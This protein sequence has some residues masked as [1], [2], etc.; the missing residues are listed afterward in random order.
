M[1]YNEDILTLTP[2][3]IAESRLQFSVPL[4]QRLFAWGHEQVERLLLD[5]HEH[6]MAKKRTTPY[7]LGMITVAR[8]NMH[9]DLIDGQQRFTMLAL[10]AIALQWKDFL[11]N[12]SFL[13]FVGRPD[14]KAY[15]KEL[16]RG[17]QATDTGY[18]NKP[19]EQA[20][21]QIRTF[22]EA[23][24][25]FPDGWQVFAEKVMKQ[26]TLFVTVLDKHYVEH[27]S[28]LNRYFENMNSCGKSLE[29]H[30]ILKV[31]LLNRCTAGQEQKAAIWNAV[32]A[33]NR[34][35]LPRMHDESTDDY[36]QRLKQIIVDVLAEGEL[37]HVIGETVIDPQD[38]TT[39]DVIPPRKKAPD[40][41]RETNSEDAIVTFPEFLLMVLNLHNPTQR[42]N[43]DPSRLL[44]AFEMEHRLD[45]LDRFY[46][47][48]LIYRLL[49]DYYVVR[50]EYASSGSRYT[51]WFRDPHSDSEASTPGEEAVLQYESMLEVSTSFYYWL[52][53]LL[54]WLRTQEHKNLDSNLL[55]TKLKE[56]DQ[57]IPG[58]EEVPPME[59][60]SYRSD[61]RYWFWLLDY[62]L[63]E[64]RKTLF[65]EEEMPAVKQYVFRRNRSIEHLH[66]QNQA[67]NESWN[68]EEIDHFGNLAMISQGLN[69]YQSNKPVNEKFAV[70]EDQADRRILQS[71]KL[72]R[73]YLDAKGKGTEWT[74]GEH[75]TMKRHAHDMYQLL[76]TFR[77][78]TIAN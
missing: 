49:M 13:T 6:F 30:E 20:L 58:H 34:P 67:N 65:G 9:Y 27:P 16:I 5:L 68:Q 77:P 66:P 37:G 42:S 63:W 39:I 61:N 62:L 12:E 11:L 19:M 10:L 64:N 33:M 35:L 15:L 24:D 38:S 40:M 8:R 52:E 75:G 21:L 25:M 69:S 46:R 3:A 48:L 53:P 28:A 14:D 22:L 47:D 60:L 50:R 56:I 59:K 43:A 7:Y 29:Q 71:L 31:N 32:S 1:N 74:P 51:L 17:N 44:P 36:R 26:T 72:Y 73:M 78:P 23:Q 41:I 18:V 76:K 45:D 4:Y 54:A 2:S 55:L 70:V 57:H